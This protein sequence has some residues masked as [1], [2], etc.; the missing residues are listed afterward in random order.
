MQL[1]K[2]AS[3]SAI[4]QRLRDCRHEK[5]RSRS[6]V[7][8]ASEDSTNPSITLAAYRELPPVDMAATALEGAASPF[9]DDQRAAIS[10]ALQSLIARA[11]DAGFPELHLCL[12]GVSLLDQVFEGNQSSPLIPPKSAGYPYASQWYEA[13][14]RAMFCA[15]WRQKMTG[16]DISVCCLQV[17]RDVDRGMQPY[18]RIWD[19]F[20]LQAPPLPAD[21]KSV[22]EALQAEA[23]KI[24]RWIKAEDRKQPDSDAIPL[25]R[26]AKRQFL[27][28][29][30]WVKGLE[31]PLPNWRELYK[32]DVEH[33]VLISLQLSKEAQTKLEEQ[34]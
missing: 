32:R 31:K 30:D 4:E 27:A 7:V 12:Q 5:R 6:K 19:V 3:R 11:T 8:F 33:C 22:E 16:D 29:R 21:E 15:I 2:K 1:V 26:T 13:R 23:S 18:S 14:A 20:K 17:A 34:K 10:L 24:Q 25:D 9:L 28:A